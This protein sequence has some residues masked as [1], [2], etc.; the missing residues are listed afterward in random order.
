MHSFRPNNL[1]PPFHLIAILDD[2]LAAKSGC[3]E[4]D[5]PGAAME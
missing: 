3:H 5:L 2:M 1:P 4:G